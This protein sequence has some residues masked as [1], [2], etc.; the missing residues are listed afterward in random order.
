MRLAN[1]ADRAALVVRAEGDSVSIA[2]VAETSDGRFGPDPMDLLEAWD[3]FRLWARTAAP[4][5]VRTV[6]RAALS[7][8]VPRPRQIFGVGTNYADHADEVGQTA[9]QSVF[10]KLPTS[11]VGPVATVTLPT[12][13]VDWEVELVVVVGRPAFRIPAARAWDHLA[14][15]MVG[16]DLSERTSQFAGELPQFSLAKSRPGFGPTGP[17]LT[18]PDELDDPTD[19][20][21]TC[22]HNAESLQSGRTTQMIMKVDAVVASIAADVP[23]LPGD[24]I[25]TGTPS[26]TGHGRHPRQY[27]VDGDHLVSEISG[28]GRI[29]QHLVADRP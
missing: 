19:L 13:T 20:A 9:H 17:W 18:T 8:P 29:E 12:T 22:R 26:G 27:L 11:L 24:L 4:D 14:G 3:E 16:Q 28:L 2:D 1:H 6:S 21:L 7:A 23:L 5:A 15:L 10:V 25:F